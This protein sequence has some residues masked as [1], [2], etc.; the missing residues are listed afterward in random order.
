MKTS[1]NHTGKLAIFKHTH[2]HSD[3]YRKADQE[4][5]L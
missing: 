4:A 3:V 2:T 1:K 5:H